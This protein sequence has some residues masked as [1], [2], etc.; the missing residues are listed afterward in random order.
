MYSL[1]GLAGAKLCVVGLVGVVI[2]LLVRGFCAA[3]RLPHAANAAPARIRVSNRPMRTK[4]FR[5]PTDC[6]GS[7]SRLPLFFFAII[8]PFART[9]RPARQRAGKASPYPTG[10]W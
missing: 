10:C 8:V 9:P 5:L 2:L 7:L 4:V 1:D 6:T 3:N